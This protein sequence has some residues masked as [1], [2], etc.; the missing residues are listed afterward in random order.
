VDYNGGL[1]FCT[2]GGDNNPTAAVW[3]KVMFQ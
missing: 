3:R 1:H 2:N